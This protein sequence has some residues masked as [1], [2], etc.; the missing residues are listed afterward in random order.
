MVPVT[1]CCCL[2]RLFEVGPGLLAAGLLARQHDGAVAVL[3]A[4][5]VELDDVAGLDL[6][7]GA[8]GAEFLERDAAFAL[9]A[10]VD[11]GVFVGEPHDPAGDD[12]AVEAAVAAEG[13][14][15]Q[16]GEIFARRDGRVGGGR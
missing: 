14:V 8:G 2:E 5:D 1:R 16:G 3:V 9:Q 15:E 13:L 12:G 10:D 7:L 11:D 4:L 6:G